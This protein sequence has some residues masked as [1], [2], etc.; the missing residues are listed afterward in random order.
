[1]RVPVVPVQPPHPPSNITC[2]ASTSSEGARHTNASLIKWR[3]LSGPPLFP[4]L[5]TYWSA[6]AAQSK[7]VVVLRVVPV[8]HVIGRTVK[9]SVDFTIVKHP[10]LLPMVPSKVIVTR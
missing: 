7:A 4:F 1:M 6:K 2:M 3:P 8:S 10:A 5:D 9:D